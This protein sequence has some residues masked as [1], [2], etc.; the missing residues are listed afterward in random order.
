MQAYA[1]ARARIVGASSG[2]GAA[3]SNGSSGG[4]ATGNSN[5]NSNSSNNNRSQS[6]P[7]TPDSS[8]F[9]QTGRKQAGRINLST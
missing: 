2:N 9:V 6:E 1:E 7:L 3:A 8:P 4:N 5:S